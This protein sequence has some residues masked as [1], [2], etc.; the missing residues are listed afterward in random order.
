MIAVLLVTCG[1]VYEAVME[2]MHVKREQVKQ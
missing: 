1:V 2:L